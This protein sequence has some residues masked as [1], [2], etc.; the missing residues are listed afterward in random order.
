MKL[1]QGFTKP[2]P[3]AGVAV[4]YII[5]FAFLTLALREIEMIL[6]YAT[7]AGAGLALVALVGIFVFREGITALKV[8]SMVLIILG[9][10]GL[11][12]GNGPR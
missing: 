11:N 5:C 1:S 7:W 10:I 9:V 3:S 12:L 4:F 6:A 2:L 8:V